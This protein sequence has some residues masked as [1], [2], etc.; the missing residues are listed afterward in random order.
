MLLFLLIR[1]QISTYF[2]IVTYKVFF[3][4]VKILKEKTYY[5]VHL[6]KVFI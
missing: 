6:L 4:F 2:Y 1:H 5:D 3:E